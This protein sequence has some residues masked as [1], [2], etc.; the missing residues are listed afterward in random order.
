MKNA[1]ALQ[2]VIADLEKKQAAAAKTAAKAETARAAAAAK[3][4]KVKQLAY[5]FDLQAANIAAAQKRG[6]TGA[7]ANRLDL[8]SLL[9]QESAGLPV[10]D[11]ALA[12]AQQQV[13][14]ITINNAGSVVTE[15]ELTASISAQLMAQRIRSGTVL[16]SPAEF[17]FFEQSTR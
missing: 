11:A 14:N 4:L 5:K 1:A 16:G 8:L 15:A 17:R 12:K 6:Q 7:I 2:K 13:V 9:N 10:S 3:T